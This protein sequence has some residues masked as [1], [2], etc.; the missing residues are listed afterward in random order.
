[1]QSVNN[2]LYDA[3]YRNCAPRGVVSN[4]LC[5]ARARGAGVLRSVPTEGRAWIGLLACAREPRVR[6]GKTLAG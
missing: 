5:L 4:E 6:V 1:M 3:I 2:T